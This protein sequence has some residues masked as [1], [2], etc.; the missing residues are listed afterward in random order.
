MVNFP[1]YIESSYT[2]G[3]MKL[4]S[5]AR[6]SLLW[7]VSSIFFTGFF[8]YFYPDFFNE[9]LVILHLRNDSLI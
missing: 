1:S 6:L 3:P 9:V 4:L 5:S 8:D 7:S 2:E